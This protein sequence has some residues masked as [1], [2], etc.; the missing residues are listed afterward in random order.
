MGGAG[1]LGATFVGGGDF[2]TVPP[3]S[4]KTEYC[5]EDRCPGETSDQCGDGLDY[6][7]EQDWLTSLYG[8]YTPAV[9]L[10]D[11]LMDNSSYF[12]HN[13]SGTEWWDKKIDYIFTNGGWANT[14]GTTHQ[15]MFNLSDHAPVSAEFLLTQ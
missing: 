15:D 1:G 7:T 3:G 11:Y 5:D 14:T 6:T 8:D 13:R 2:N 12:T 4:E 10:N 9:A